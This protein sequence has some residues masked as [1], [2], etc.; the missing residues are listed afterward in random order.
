VISSRFVA[1]TLATSVSA[2]G[3]SAQSRDAA[4]TELSAR[5]L[6][7]TVALHILPLAT[8]AASR[9]ALAAALEEIN[10]TEAVT[11]VEGRGLFVEPAPGGA[12]ALNRVSGEGWVTVDPRLAEVLRRALAF[13]SWS[14]N[15][16]G[17]LAGRLHELWGIHAGTQPV[18]TVPNSTALATAVQAARCDGLEIEPNGNRARLEAGRRVDLWSFARGFAVDRAV[19]TLQAQGVAAG[20]VR[21]GRVLRVFGRGA[22]SP[23]GWPV[24]IDP[25]PGG[26][27]ATE[28]IVLENQA[29]AM[30]SSWSEPVRIADAELPP[31]INQRDGQPPRDVLAILT[32]TELAVDAEALA[33]TLFVL[34]QREGQLLLGGL[35]PEPAV[36]WYLGREGPPLT[37]EQRWSRLP[38]WG[39]PAP[40]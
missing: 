12:M 25:A 15:A 26:T 16:I 8:S 14:N 27:A 35:T 17:P 2:L 11:W 21:I 22:D 29:L 3:L 9:D 39:S 37:S 38:T 23:R 18:E 6:G 24:S 36:K 7:T 5:A 4:T 40:R 19:A 1:F 20:S 33:A 31:F 10:R 32:V 30:A 13:C 34:G 28:R